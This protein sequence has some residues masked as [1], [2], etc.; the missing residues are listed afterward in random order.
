LVILGNRTPDGVSGGEAAGAT[1]TSQPASG[2]RSTVDEPL[3]DINV[4]GTLGVHAST[5]A[6]LAL[7]AGGVVPPGKERGW[8]TWPAVKAFVRDPDNANTK[9]QRDFYE[10]LEKYRKAVNSVRELKNRGEDDK[11][12]AYSTAKAEELAR[13]KGAETAAKKLA[14]IRKKVRAIDWD[15]SLTPAEK[16]EAI[17]DYNAEAQAV[18]E[19]QT[20]LYRA[21]KK[22]YPRAGFAGAHE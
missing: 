10:Q 22:S 18:V 8:Q 6:D 1:S 20:A 16:R 3:R 9:Q 17:N 2:A 19:E 7:E 21:V 12:E 5:V 15:R 4:F 13:A 11:A 14:S